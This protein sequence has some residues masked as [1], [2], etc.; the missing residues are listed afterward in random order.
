M[1]APVLDDNARDAVTR[2][3]AAIV[4]YGNATTELAHPAVLSVASYALARAYGH[5]GVASPRPLTWFPQA[6][7]EKKRQGRGTTSLSSVGRKK[8]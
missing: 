8:A 1:N 4:R 5:D 3:F 7:L 6:G 2:C